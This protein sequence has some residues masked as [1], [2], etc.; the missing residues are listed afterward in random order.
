MFLWVSSFLSVI[1]INCNSSKLWFLGLWTIH[2]FCQVHPSTQLSLMINE[3]WYVWEAFSRSIT[4]EIILLRLVQ[5]YTSPCSFLYSGLSLSQT[6]IYTHA[7]CQPSITLEKYSNGKMFLSFKSPLF[8]V[9]VLFL[10]SIILFLY[11]HIFLFSYFVS[12]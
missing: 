8:S 11:N 3:R 9:F 6:V 5:C 7:E 10:S 4:F 12:F 2:L 1:Y